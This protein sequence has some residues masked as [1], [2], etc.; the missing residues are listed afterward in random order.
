MQ[1]TL[2]ALCFLLTV[3]PVLLAVMLFFAIDRQASTVQYHPLTS[4]DIQRAQQILNFSK[5]E[6]QNIRTLEL[7]Q[8]DL[9]TAVN[10]LL[11]HLMQSAAKVSLGDDSLDFNISLY[12]P[13]N[14]FGRYMNIHFRLKKV[15]GYPVINQLHIGSIRIADEFA[16]HIIESIINHTDLKQYYILAS[17]HIKNLSINPK[18]LTITYLTRFN[19]TADQNNLTAN[20]DYQSLIFYQQKINQIVIQ[21]NPR[22]RLSLADILQP[23]FLAAYQRSTVETAI[24]ENRA[25]LIATSS[26]VN[27]AELKNY[28]P[29]YLSTAK[30]YPVYLYKRVDLA[31]H[32]V[33][34]A[35]LAATGA[36]SLTQMLGQEKELSD[37]KTRSG[38]SFTDLAAD[39][40]GLKLGQTATE[41]PKSARN[42]QKAMHNIKDYRAFMP[43]VRDLPENLTAQVFKRFYGSIYSQKYQNM[44][45]LID[46]RI[47][48]LPVY[49]SQ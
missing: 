11:N 36:V 35:A 30:Y 43:E 40:A 23:L 26:Y 39:R 31:K 19:D 47:A 41:T 2:R 37:L 22:Y 6:Q 44:L 28:F 4:R 25:L 18:Q 49:Q 34:S 3:P 24:R 38:F 12:L 16:G 20:A 17:Q 45:K 13:D 8:Q 7:T 42:L 9:N 27:K 1:A 29:I 21:H 48:Q 32:F 5:T 14:L 15:A 46:Q 10:Y 33:G